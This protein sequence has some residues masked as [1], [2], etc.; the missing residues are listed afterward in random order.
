MGERW[1][2]EGACR[3]ERDGEGGRSGGEGEGRKVIWEGAGREKEDELE[4]TC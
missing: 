2:R 1:R 4:D 3:E